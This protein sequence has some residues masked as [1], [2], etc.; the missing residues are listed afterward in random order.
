MKKFIVLLVVVVFLVTGFFWWSH[1]ISAVDPKD[2]NMHLITIPLGTTSQEIAT[3]LVHEGLIRDSFAFSLLL[4]KLGIGDK[5]QAGSFA[6]SK[7]MD[8]ETIAK[9]LTQSSMDIAVTIPEG[10]RAEEVAEILQATMPTYSETWR[11][12]L[13]KHEGFLFPDTYRFSRDATIEQI[14]ATMT[15]TFEQKYKQVTNS[16][17]FSRE[18]IVVLASMI[19][20]EARHA[21]DRPLVSSVMHNRLQINMAL[22]IDATVQYALG[23]NQ[24]EQTWWKKGLTTAD[25]AINSPYNTYT[26]PGLPPTPIANPGLA[27][28]QAAAAPADTNYLFYITDKQGINHYARTLEEHNTNIKKYGL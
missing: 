28:L 20:R 21:D 16:T 13:T 1:S 19:E 25:L 22:Q 9:A 17:D 6:L 14:V 26:N 4:K 10:K 23:F 27:S 5:L 3:T 8:A 24:Q 7:S 18:Q 12:E 15:D 11:L 2:T